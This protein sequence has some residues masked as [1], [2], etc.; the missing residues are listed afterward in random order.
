MAKD[1]QAKPGALV[2]IIEIDCVGIPYLPKV[3]DC[4]DCVV[5]ERRPFLTGGR[6][7]IGIRRFVWR[8]ESL[9]R[10]GSPDVISRTLRSC[11]PDAETCVLDL[12]ASRFRLRKLCLLR[13][14]TKQSP[15]SNTD[16]HRDSFR[17]HLLTARA[18]GDAGRVAQR[19]EAPDEIIGAAPLSPELWHHT[20]YP[21]P[22]RLT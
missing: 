11:A 14:G 5:V 7:D 9:A 10:S 8:R 12:A 6:P 1:D 21:E 20:A 13:I 4:A 18:H 15:I 22:R 3:V 19:D 16:H 2:V 17:S